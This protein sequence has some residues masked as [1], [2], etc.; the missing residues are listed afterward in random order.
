MLGTSIGELATSSLTQSCEQSGGEWVYPMWLSV[1]P[2]T[3]DASAMSSFLMISDQDLTDETN[4][5]T[6]PDD[7]FTLTDNVPVFWSAGNASTTN[8]ITAD[9]TT[10]IFVTNASATEEALLTIQSLQDPTPSFSH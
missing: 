7:T 5:G 1:A 3:A 10:N 8:P 6:V 9:V 4:S 2:W